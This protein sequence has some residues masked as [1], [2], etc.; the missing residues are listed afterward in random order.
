MK[1]KGFSTGIWVFGATPDRFCV[2]GYIQV[3]TLKNHW[4]ELPRFPISL[5]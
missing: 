2:T 5:A 4:I 1:S 3:E